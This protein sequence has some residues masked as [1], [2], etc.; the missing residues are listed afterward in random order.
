[1]KR[2]F[3]GIKGAARGYRKE[4]LASRLTQSVDDTPLDPTTMEPGG[5]EGDE[6]D[7]L[8]MESQSGAGSEVAAGE[9]SEV[10]TPMS[11]SKEEDDEMKRIKEMVRRA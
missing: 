1:M 5:T 2:V 3:K 11:A 6:S 8:P 4:K 7:P 10:E 9:T